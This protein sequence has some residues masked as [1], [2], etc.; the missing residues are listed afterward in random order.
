[1]AVN[2]GNLNWQALSA[3]A[4]GNTVGE[5]LGNANNV[6]AGQAEKAQA[7]NAENQTRAWLAKSFPG[8][9]FDGLQGQALSMAFSD[10]LRQ[11][12]EAQQPKYTSAGNGYMFDQRTGQYI[13]P[14]AS[15]DSAKSQAEYGL[16][17]QY[18]VDAQGNPVLIQMSK[19][20]RSVQSQLPE[21]VK[22]SKEPIKLDAGTHFVLL[23]PIT[24]QPVGQIPKNVAEV[25]RQKV[26]GE[27]DGKNTA[28]APADLQAGLNAKALIEELKTDPNREM[29]TGWSGWLTNSVPATPGYDYQNKVNQA[30]SGAFLT[31]IQQLR[32]MGSLSN[33]EGDT[34]TKAVTRMNT[35]T[36][37]QAFLEAL[38]DYE[39][40]IDQGI[41]RAK[42]RL[43]PG[44]Q[45]LQAAPADGVNTT[46]SGV[47]WKKAP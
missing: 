2:L 5:Q 3:L 36:S 35:A 40:I 43:P 24:R 46:S 47:K 26:I 22:L 21:G 34:A 45:D 44:Q 38:D 4:S 31:A 11:R 25:E 13:A 8:Q 1:M 19:D 9:N 27:T 7:L 23:D 37:E 29:G 28:A 30:K 32:G 17:P 10:A 41:A 39:K 42:T 15:F 20:G 6:M 33:A 14:P 16:N 18:G 12:A